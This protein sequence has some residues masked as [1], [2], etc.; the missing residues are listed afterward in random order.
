MCWGLHVSE[1]WATIPRGSTSSTSEWAIAREQFWC[2]GAR[3]INPH[4]YAL[5]L[6]PCPGVKLPGILVSASVRSHSRVAEVFGLDV[7]IH[8]LLSRIEL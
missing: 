4:Q 5:S 8:F 2:P 7:H 3:E 6:I 1:M